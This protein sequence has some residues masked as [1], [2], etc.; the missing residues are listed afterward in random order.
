MDRVA[1]GEAVLMDGATGTEI[2]RRGVPMLDN[3]WNGGGALSHPGILRAVHE[4]YL[5]EGAE[6]VIS[7]TFATSR[8]ALRD[9]GVEGDFEALNRRGVALAIEARER[10]D[11]PQALVAGGISYW[12][13]S[14]NHPPLAALGPG[15]AEQAAMMADEG[16]DLLMLEMMVDIERMMVTLEAATAVGLPVWVGLTCGPDSA[17]AMGLRNGDPLPE[18]LALL[19][20]HAVALVNVM[21]TEV[22]HVDASLD[23]LDAHWTG[24]VGVYAHSARF[25]DHKCL[26]DETISPDA[27][28]ALARHWLDRGVRVIGGCCGIGVEH[29]AAL[30]PLVAH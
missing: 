7:N 29:I 22:E 2:E 5:R 27:Y 19:Q 17:G 20:D 14:G 13:W 30:R 26:F 9:A 21:H 25:K 18:A 6:I 8:H 11:K 10:M 15:I 23:V 16:A 24:P 4:D 3:A 12:S 1:A 28:A